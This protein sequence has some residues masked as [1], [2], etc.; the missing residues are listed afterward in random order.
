MPE[1]ALVAMSGGVDSSVAAAVLLDKGLQCIGATFNFFEKDENDANDARQAAEKLNM[2]HFVFDSTGEFRKEV[3]ERF[4]EAYEQ[5]LTPNPCIDCNRYI[6]FSRLFHFANKHN[7]ELIATGHYAQTE[8]SGSRWLLKK[9]ADI[10]KDQSYVL[11]SLRQKL[12][13]HTSFPLG[14]L[15]KS[16]VREIARECGFQNADKK[17]SQDICFVHDGD[18]GAFMEQYTGKQYPHG[19]ILDSGGKLL[20]R[21]R[22]IVRY[23]LG[24]RRG[25]GIALNQPVY[26]CAKD[27]ARNTVTLGPEA[28]LYSKALYAN[29]INL[30]AC[31]SLE[32]PM[33]LK[34]KTRY[35]QQEYS[36][37]VVQIAKDEIRIEF[38]EAR[39]ALT[40]GQAAVFY[41]GDIVIGGGIIRIVE[42]HGNSFYL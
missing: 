18:Y 13:E 22:G 11:F 12:L 29:R 25:L 35:L 33:K 42:A 9:A 5:G 14:T 21:H 39:R 1:K 4:I 31:E 23:T 6:K 41:D 16:K 19:D 27:T 15:S 8:K 34:V 26:V 10:S 30:I 24:Q 36:A 32:K 37:R 17:E 20:G 38:D 3:I 40:P 7:C 28:S 2:P